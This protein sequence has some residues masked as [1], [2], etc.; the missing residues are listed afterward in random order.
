M[1]SRTLNRFL[2]LIK[3]FIR[4]SGCILK[5]HITQRVE[6]EEMQCRFM[7]GC[8]NLHFKAAIEVAPDFLQ[9]ILHHFH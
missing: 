4:V 1:H 7:S 3:R 5:R 2:K 9:A 6:I 8:C